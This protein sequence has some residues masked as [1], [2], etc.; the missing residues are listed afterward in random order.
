M[1]LPTNESTEDMETFIHYF[2][3]QHTL[4]LKAICPDV[5]DAKLLIEA[6]KLF[7]KP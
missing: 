6:M 2:G 4:T 5:N 1:N 3:A 7:G